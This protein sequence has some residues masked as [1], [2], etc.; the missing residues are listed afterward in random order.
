M[1]GPYRRFDPSELRVPGEPEPTIAESADALAAARDLEALAVGDSIR[2]TEGFEDRVMAAI[3]AEPAPR[4]VI[5]AGNQVRGGRPAAFLLALRDAWGVA[6]NGGRPFAAR[7][8]ALALVLV[9]VLAAGM[10]A[11]LGAVTV[12]GLFNRSSSP[13]PSVEPAP[14]GPT[15]PIPTA[16]PPTPTASPT[17]GPTETAEPTETPEPTESAETEGAI[18]TT[19]PATLSTQ[20]PDR[21]PGPTETAQ[22]T[23]DY[24]VGGNNTPEPTETPEPSD[25]LGG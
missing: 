2:P 6:T 19:K 20:R 21:T 15:T 25:D 22:P 13:A 9:V 12:G 23:D 18:E 8:Q 16:V 14:S 1:S 4:V 10:L 11:G 17:P 5:R 7:A 24:G 3:A